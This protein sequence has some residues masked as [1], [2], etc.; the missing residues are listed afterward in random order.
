MAASPPRPLRRPHA[1][2]S[3]FGTRID[4]YHWLRD[5]S[6]SDP[7]VLAHLRAE[8]A[9]ADAMLEPRT[10]LREQ[11][12]AELAGR[13][14]DADAS[15]PARHN[16]WWYQTRDEPGS[17]HPRHLRR[18]DLPDAPWELLVDGEARAAAARAAGS[19][20][21][22]LG[23]LEVSHDN[24][25]LAVA[26]DTVGR[27]LYEIRFRDLQ[28]GEWLPDVVANA[29]PNLAWANDGGSLLYVEKDPGTLLGSRV[30]RHRVG[31]PAAADELVH[32]EADDSF[33]VGVAKSRSERFLFIVAQATLTSE[34]RYADAADPALAFRVA[35]PREDG[36]DYEL[37]HRGGE[38]LIRSNWQAPDFRLAAAAIDRVGDRRAWRDLLPP[39]EGVAITGFEVLAGWLAVAERSGARR[40]IRLLADDGSGE[41]LIEPPDAAGTIL[42]GDNPEPQ[43]AALRYL[44][45]APASPTCTWELP[46]AGGE[47]VL[48]KRDP[49]PGGFDPQ[50]YAA[51]LRWISARDGVRVPVTLLRRRDLAERGQPCPLY[52]CGYGAYG[53]S[54]DPL[55]QPEMLS[56]VDRGF[57]YAFAHVRGGQELGRA[58][59]DAGR[60]QN[61]RRGIEDFVDVTRALVAEGIA[62]PA[63]LFAAGGSAGGTLVAAAANDS[64]DLYRGV[65]AHKPFVDVLTSM[66]DESLP[67][68]TNEYEEWGDPGGSAEAYGSILAWSPYDGV[69]AA[70]YPAVYATTGLWDS[71]VQYWEPAK[72]VARLRESSTSGQ[73]VLLRA[74]LASGHWGLTGR[75][76]HCRELAEEYAFVLWQAGIG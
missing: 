38:F 75:F 55:F 53:I 54:E 35:V 63:H 1:V 47:P 29:E 49:V 10:G 68:T 51:E 50:A 58:W 48:L 72:W 65:V 62:D 67:L 12:R 21:Y 23:A 19:E 66:L 73:P 28:T 8:N 57:A 61:K 74:Q 76:E 42:P 3:R 46:L 69:R 43:A 37:E 52:Q 15:V 6:R 70:G 14:P 13:I 36:H 34:W 30:L 4:P 71:Q 59:Y 18:R 45:S 32:E 24:R 41:R 7:A 22:D 25:L 33:F 44:T 20:H 5:D 27:G 11:L 56:L 40:R 9:Y 16:G 26:E 31:T 39:R 2:H 64:P 17:E 60:L